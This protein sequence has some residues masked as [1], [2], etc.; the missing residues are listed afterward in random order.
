MELQSH[1]VSI[2][3]QRIKT[4][5]N[6][7][8]GFSF[9]DAFLKRQFL[10]QITDPRLKAHMLFFAVGICHQTYALADASQNLYGWDYLEDGFLRM[11]QSGSFLLEPS[12]VAAKNNLQVQQELRKFFSPGG[13]PANCTLDRLDERAKLYTD[14]AKKLC[15]KFQCNFL[16]VIRVANNHVVNNTEGFYALLSCFDAYSDPLFKK[17]SFL[18]KLLVDAG[19]IKL[20]DPEN[21]VPV[22]DYHMQR[23]LLRTGC[24]KIVSQQLE[25]ALKNRIQ[26][27]YEPQI[28][29]ECIE[30]MRLIAQKAGKDILR[31]NDVFYMIGRSCCLDNPLCI[32]GKCDKNPCSLT[33]SL[34]LDNHDSCVLKTACTAATNPAYAEYWHP[35]TQTHF[36]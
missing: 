18:I 3:H 9:N 11:A 1:L 36:Y 4:I 25:Y 20:I 29:T 7:V 14:M 30:A 34:T 23:V 16:E 6:I 21:L 15:N 27:Q 32:S 19:Y 24:I 2:D 5:S 33:R 10:T 35:I 26:T 12:E 22:M 28:R 13:N 8:A 31:M 17:S